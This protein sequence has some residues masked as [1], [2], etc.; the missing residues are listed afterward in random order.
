[1]QLFGMKTPDYGY[2]IRG[3]GFSRY[4]MEGI[5]DSL[6]L[7]LGTPVARWMVEQLPLEL[8]GNLFEKSRNI[9]KKSTK[10]IKRQQL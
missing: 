6:F 5:I 10:N 4:L 1:M 9:W 7:L 8:V 2:V 3:F